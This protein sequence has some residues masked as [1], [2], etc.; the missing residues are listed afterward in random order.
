MDDSVILIR[1]LFSHVAS[2]PSNLSVTSVANHVVSKD[3]TDML[4]VQLVCLFL[5]IPGKP[6]Y[7]HRYCGRSERPDVINVAASSS[8]VKEV[9]KLGMP[10]RINN[11]KEFLFDPLIDGAPGL[12]PQR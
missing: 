3:L 5:T 6:G 2:G 7:M 4:G 11:V 1:R 8:L 9:L 10:V 12:I